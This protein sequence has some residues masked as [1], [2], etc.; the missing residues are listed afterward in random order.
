MPKR[1]SKR[2]SRPKKHCK[3]MKNVGKVK[4]CAR[5]TGIMGDGCGSYASVVDYGMIGNQLNKHA[6]IG[7]SDRT[8][9]SNCPSGFEEF[10]G[11]ENGKPV[12]YCR[13]RRTDAI[14]KAN[15]TR[16]G[17]EQ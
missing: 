12:R 8:C 11:D 9:F 4:R 6:A 16:Q 2:N 7:R 13:D 3:S 1:S 14:T 5:Y 17:K 15:I 10:E